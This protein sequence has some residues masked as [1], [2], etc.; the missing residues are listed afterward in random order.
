[1]SQENIAL[2][3]KDFTSDQDVRWCPGCGD[4]AIL[5]AVQRTLAELQA[6]NQKNIAQGQ[7]ELQ[8]FTSDKDRDLQRQLQNAINEAKDTFDN[9]AQKLQ[10]FQ[11]EVGEY[12]AEVAAETQEATLKTQNYQTQ[13][14]WIKQ[15]YE[16]GFIPF[17]QP[18]RR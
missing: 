8:R 15:Q 12:Q 16:E 4:Y 1:M 5:K 10:L 13:Y 9:N 11:S 18:E 17:Q 3:K 6:E 2:T 7:A 14:T